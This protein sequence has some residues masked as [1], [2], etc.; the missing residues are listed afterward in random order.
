MWFQTSLGPSVQGRAALPPTSTPPGPSPLGL[1][2]A[3]G[4]ADLQPVPS[5]DWKP[6]SLGPCLECRL[7]SIC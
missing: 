4:P 3:Q 7:W 1:A 5:T 6:G 2:A